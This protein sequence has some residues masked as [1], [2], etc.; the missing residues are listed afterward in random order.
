MISRNPLLLLIVVM[1]TIAVA[2]AKSSSSWQLWRQ[3][4]AHPANVKSSPSIA[5]EN[6][7]G[8]N[9]AIWPTKKRGGVVRTKREAMD[10]G[11][12]VYRDDFL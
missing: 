7:D 4:P 2:S 8:N 1:A 6:P 12:F 3:H 10:Y 5:D 9:K 11:K